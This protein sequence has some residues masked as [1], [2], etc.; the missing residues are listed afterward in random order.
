[1]NK[2]KHT[3]MKK[4]YMKPATEL[5]EVELVSML[6]G[7]PTSLNFDSSTHA[8]EELS[9]NRRGGWGNLWE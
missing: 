3:N 6:A 8:D 9:N 1:M 5:V 2:I 4:E 7:S